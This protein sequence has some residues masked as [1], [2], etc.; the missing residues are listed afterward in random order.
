[1]AAVRFPGSTRVG[2]GDRRR[3]PLHAH[4]SHLLLRLL[5]TSVGQTTI[6][7]PIA[8]ILTTYTSPGSD[9]SSTSSRSS[10]ESEPGPDFDDDGDDALLGIDVNPFGDEFLILETGCSV[11]ARRRFETISVR[12]VL[13]SYVFIAAQRELFDAPLEPTLARPK[14][15]WEIFVD[16]GRLSQCLEKYGSDRVTDEQFS[17]NNGNDFLDDIARQNL[18]AGRDSEKPDE[19]FMAPLC[20]PWRQMQNVNRAVRRRLLRAS[21]CQTSRARALLLTLCRRLYDGQA[22]DGLHA[23]FEA[24]W[25]ANSIRTKT[26]SNMCGYDARLDQCRFQSYATAVR[27]G[28]R[29][30]GLVKKPTRICTTKMRLAVQ[31]ARRCSCVNPHVPLE[32]SLSKPAQ[33]YPWPLAAELARLIFEPNYALRERRLRLHLRRHVPH[34]RGRLRDC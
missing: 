14:V 19:I 20:G 11:E 5:R 33:N 13:R 7:V 8:T 29:V 27:F 18:I 3:N 2:D 15:I 17:L 1:M 24:P 22:L 16:E 12:K 9:S 31:I 34:A 21:R 6:A 10:D 30:Y 28:T 4:S 26:W 32:G 25:T 23:H